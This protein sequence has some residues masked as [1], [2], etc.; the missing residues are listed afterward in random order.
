[1]N[2]P[3]NDFGKVAVLMGGWSAERDISL[4]S[5]AAVLKAL[6]AQGVD[7]HGIDVGHDIASV[8]E[9]N[10]F[11]RAFIALHGRGGEDGTMQGLLSAM[12]IPYTGSRILGSALSMD[13]LRTKQIWQAA[14]LP[15]PE[16]WILDSEA[17]CQQAIEQGGLPLIIKPVLEGSSIGMSK[18]EK[19]SD[20]LAAWQKAKDCGGRVIA[21]R[22]IHGAE[23]TAAVLN[24]RVLPMI[25]LETSHL[26][27][28]YDA[29]YQ[30]EDTK[31]ICPC[32]LDVDDE[33]FLSQMITGAFDAVGASGW[34]RVDFMIDNK[35]QPWLIEVNTV[36]GMTD[37][38]LVPMA[39]KQAGINFEQ[40]VIEILK[41]AS[42]D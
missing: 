10:H 18:V 33:K 40:L 16:Y 12:D 7:A 1:M 4:L 27:Y 20:M 26:F 8:L 37:H 30:A 31:Y 23:Y 3:V 28:D 13:K 22:W 24:G 5:G 11:D 6:K 32:G 39:A 9:Q 19:D 29:K 17:D 34:G 14:G 21:E 36:P 2:A 41:G 38:S 25:R 42:Y 15:T 35:K